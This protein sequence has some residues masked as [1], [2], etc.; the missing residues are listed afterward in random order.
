MTYPHRCGSHILLIISNTDGED[1]VLLDPLPLPVSQC[2][3]L[4]S[5]DFGRSWCSMCAPGLCATSSGALQLWNLLQ[6]VRKPWKTLREHHLLQDFCLVAFG[7]GNR[8]NWCE[9]RASDF[10]QFQLSTLCC[11]DQRGLLKHTSSNSGIKKHVQK[12]PEG[13]DLG[14]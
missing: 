2:F 1:R 11:R 10:L 12:A 7:A 6:L 14:N 4:R 8:M 9:Q 3:L 5:K 13:A